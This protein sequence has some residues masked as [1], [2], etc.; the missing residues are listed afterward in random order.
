M[1]I[2]SGIFFEVQ[3]CDG[4]LLDLPF[5]R[6][7]RL[8]SFSRHDLE[9]AVCREGSVILRD[10]IAF[11]KVGVEVILARKN[12]LAVY[13]KPESEG[14]ARAEFDCATIQ[15]GKSARQPQTYRAS[16]FIGLVAKSSRAATEDF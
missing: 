15:D 1:H 16:V 6:V 8:I 2:F 10:L 4:D 12:R 7:P 3:A 5:D 14:R 11:G 13:V 9:L